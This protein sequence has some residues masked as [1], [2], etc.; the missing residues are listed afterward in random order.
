MPFDKFNRRKKAVLSKRDKSSK[1]NCDEKVIS[2]CEK[3]NKKENCFTT[4][5][6][7]GRIVLMIDQDKKAEG[8]FRFVSHDLISFEELKKGLSRLAAI[9]AGFIRAWTSIRDSN[10]TTIITS[11]ILFYFT[12]SFV[13]GFAITL[14]IGVLVSMFSAITVTR[15]LLRVFIRK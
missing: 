5:S 14:L 2:L 9:D 6:C 8:L 3:I 12:S 7:S 13:K 10:L 4:S 15:T 11:V 1:G